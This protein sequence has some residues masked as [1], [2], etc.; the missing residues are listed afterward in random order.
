MVMMMMLDAGWLFL[1][2]LMHLL[3]FHPPAIGRGWK[4][5]YATWERAEVEERLRLFKSLS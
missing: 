4:S 5:T 1:L 2:L 3:P